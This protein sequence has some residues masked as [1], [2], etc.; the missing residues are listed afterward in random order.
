MTT[1][2]ATVQGALDGIHLESGNDPP[3]GQV[4]ALYETATGAGQ[5]GVE[6]GTTMPIVWVPASFGCPRG[7]FG[8]PCFRND[9]LPLVFLFTDAS[10]HMSPSG[11]RDY[12]ICG[13]TPHTYAQA[14]DGLTRED[15][16]VIGFWSG[17]DGTTEADMLQIVRDTG[18]VD[19]SGAP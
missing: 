17:D 18:A 5:S 1:D 19:S 13:T 11:T 3:E 9:S 12:A 15:I 4:E 10:F 2:L 8:Y 14:R 6:C 7:G 16:R